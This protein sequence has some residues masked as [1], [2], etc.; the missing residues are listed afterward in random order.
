MAKRH[1]IAL[2]ETDKYHRA[3]FINAYEGAVARADIAGNA[4]TNG[5]CKVAFDN[6]ERAHA[7]RGEGD[8]QLGSMSFEARSAVGYAP[9]R[10]A[11]VKAIAHVD[12]AF[13]R[14]CLRGKR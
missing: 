12:K 6:L 14:V 10:A 9:R 4:I 2:G 1:R 5:H 3:H 11:V 13:L 7:F 8:G